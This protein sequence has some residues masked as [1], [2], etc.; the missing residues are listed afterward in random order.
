MKSLFKQ[1]WISQKSGSSALPA[2][3]FISRS[4]QGQHQNSNTLEA[5][6]HCFK[7]CVVPENIHTSPRRE[8]FWVPPPLWKFRL[9][10]IHFF[11]FFGLT[12]PPPPGK[13]NPFC[14]GSMDIFW[15]WTLSERITWAQWSFKTLMKPNLR[16][17]NCQSRF[18]KQCVSTVKRQSRLWLSIAQMHF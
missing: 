18:P 16:T 1:N 2:L 13:S 10:F 7:D 11:I 8:F 4:H 5:C 12:D 14:G 9:S 17:R 15:N 3:L 6:D